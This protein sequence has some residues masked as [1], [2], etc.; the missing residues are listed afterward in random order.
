MKSIVWSGIRKRARNGEARGGPAVHS[1]C[2]LTPYARRGLCES[3]GR[4]VAIRTGVEQKG[5]RERSLRIARHP[6]GN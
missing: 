3:F 5:R 6:A 4:V 1:T 2:R